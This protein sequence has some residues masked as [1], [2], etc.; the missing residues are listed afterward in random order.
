VGVGKVMLKRVN[1][2]ADCRLFVVAG[3]KYGNI[4]LRCTLLGISHKI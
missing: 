4:Q 1:Y 2:G 3:N